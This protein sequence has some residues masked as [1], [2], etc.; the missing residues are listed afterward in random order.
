MVFSARSILNKRQR[1]SS[2]RQFLLNLFSKYL[3]LICRHAKNVT[4]TY[5]FVFVSTSHLALLWN[6]SNLRGDTSDESFSV[7][8]LSWSL[9]FR[10]SETRC[11]RNKSKSWNSNIYLT[12]SSDTIYSPGYDTQGTYPPNMSCTWLISLPKSKIK[13]SFSAFSLQPVGPSCQYGDFVEVRDG[14]Y[15]DSPVLGTFS[16][17]NIPSDTFSSGSYMLVQ[18]SSDESVEKR[19]FVMSYCSYD[20]SNGKVL[21]IKAATL[22]S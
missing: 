3:Q 21:K 2:Q 11:S 16:G 17:S 20:T 22:R 12:K 19:G 13:L 15:S 14:E 10:F 8:S 1:F 5:K 18:F 4:S 6:I 9:F 7:F